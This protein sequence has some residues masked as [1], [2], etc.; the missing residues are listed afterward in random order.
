MSCG[1]WYTAKITPESLA[2]PPVL[3]SKPS[4]SVSS[5][6]SIRVLASEPP[7]D[8]ASSALPPVIRMGVFQELSGLKC[9]NPQLC[10][11]LVQ[12]VE[13]R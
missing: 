13:R 5:V 1:V 9:S 3:L 8:E 12:A 6:D 4:I 7:P 10:V 2:Y 11:A